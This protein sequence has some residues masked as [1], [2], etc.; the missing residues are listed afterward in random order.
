VEVVVELIDL[1]DPPTILEERLDM[2]DG[3]SYTQVIHCNAR[4][5]DRNELVI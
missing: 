2:E 3:D 1:F 4:E 5:A